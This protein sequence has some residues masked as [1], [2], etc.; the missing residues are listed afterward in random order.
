MER[1]RC[2]AAGVHLGF[3]ALPNEEARALLGDDALL[4]RSLHDPESFRRT[5]IDY[6]HL[7]PIEAPRSKPA[8]RPSL[9]HAAITAAA[10]HG[11][12]VIAQG[13]IDARN[14]RRAVEAG[15]SGVAVTGAILATDDPAAAT[16]ALREAL[17]A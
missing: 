17:D 5:G 6:G 13:G 7:A 15:A 12:P 16:R 8:T 1:P 11:T 2:G 9:G 10:R 3:D 14:A 4:G